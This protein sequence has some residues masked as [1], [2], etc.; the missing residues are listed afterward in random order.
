MKKKTKRILNLDIDNEY[1]VRVSKDIDTTDLQVTVYDH[2]EG[3]EIYHGNIGKAVK[4]TSSELK[5]WIEAIIARM[6]DN[7][8]K[9]IDVDDMEK[10]EK[11]LLKTF[12]AYPSEIVKMIGTGLI[13]EDYFSDGKD[14]TDDPF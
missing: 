4:M 12:W 9:E 7:L 10:L 8:Q 5:G 3:D 2:K 11:V 1:G 6:L 14:K 13:E